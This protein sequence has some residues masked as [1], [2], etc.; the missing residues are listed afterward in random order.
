[1][2]PEKRAAEPTGLHASSDRIDKFVRIATAAALGIARHGGTYDT[3]D[4]QNVAVRLLSADALRL[5]T[6]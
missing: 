2:A 1:L 4:L 6:S 5:E 3:P